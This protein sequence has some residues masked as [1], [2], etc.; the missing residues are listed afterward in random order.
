MTD[1]EQRFEDSETEIGRRLGH[2]LYRFSR[3]TAHGSW[4]ASVLEGFAQ[5]N[6]RRMPRLAPDR[7]VRKWLQ[8]RLGALRR[9]RVVD[10]DVAPQLLGRIDIAAPCRGSS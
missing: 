7:F 6:A 4:P 2:D 3:T 1:P 9:E 5:A 10:A 8:L